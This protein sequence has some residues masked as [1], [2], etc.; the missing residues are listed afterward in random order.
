MSSS[1]MSIVLGLQMGLAM[2]LA[3]G[4]AG[5]TTTLW[6]FEGSFAPT[7][8]PGSMSVRG[9]A[10]VAFGTASS[11]GLPLLPG[12]DSGVLSFPAFTAAQG[13]NV[14]H[15]SAP[16]GVHIGDGWVSNY[17]LVMD[18]YWPASSNSQW[19][20]IL[21][22]NPTNANDGDFFI[23][24]TGRIGI[25]GVYNGVL[26]TIQSDTWHRLVI[27]FGCADG[28]GQLQKY[29]D[30]RFIGG[31]G[32]T[33]SPIT[34]AR[35]ALFA[36]AG[37]DFLLFGDN[38]GETAPGYMSSFAFLP[39]RLNQAEVA[40]LG[41]PNAAGA[42]TPGTPPAPVMG[43][44]RRVQV[45]AHRG[46]SAEA[47]ENTPS[48]LLQAA[49]LGVHAIEFDVRLTSDGV[50]V[51]MHDSTLNRTT[52]LTG[53]VT[54]ITAANLVSTADAGSWFDDRYIGERVPTIAD[55]LVL[56]RGTGVK[57]YLDVKVSGMGA[58]IAAAITQANVTPAD[59]YIWTYS[60][61]DRLGIRSFI[62]DA[63]FVTGE[64]PTSQARMDQLIAQGVV[65]F[66]LSTGQ[67][68]FT[69][70]FVDFA[71]ANGRFVWAYTVLDPDTMLAMID[72][73]VDGMETDFP[74]V[75]ESLFAP[76]QPCPG[77]A[78]GDRAITFADITEVLAN[79]GLSYPG[80]TGPGDADQNGQVNF[81]DITSV[82]TFLGTSCP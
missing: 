67:S 27:V 44:A 71:R 46:N 51:G 62:P 68:G 54:S 17:T 37:A 39:K 26:G 45:V 11:F 77:D 82:L 42:L 10:S 9:G 80:G 24:P 41:G 20:S 30:G 2:G 22:T 76:L 23:D 21:N 79:I 69:T 65:G 60:E 14:D 13:L 7:S 73:G 64:I 38:N 33:G 34:G 50:G 36:Q 8:G 43:N 6:N 19:R 12:G 78:N 35:W 15:A 32:T 75:L 48:A 52:D 81:S 55:A 1:R 25:A 47:P 4:A 5:Q 66:D 59:L 61:A 31:Q 16:N 49:T 28:E 40:A 63:R 18:V 29:I 57:L 53:N 70:Q 74:A 58:A 56:L 3:T 72:R